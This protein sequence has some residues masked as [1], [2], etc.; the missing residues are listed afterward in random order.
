METQARGNGPGREFKP[1]KTTPVY[2][3]VRDIL[4]ER[5]EAGDWQDGKSL[6][7]EVDL[8][9]EYGVSQGTIRKALDM[10]KA[11]CLVDREQGRG[12]FVRK[13]RE[14]AEIPQS[15]KDLLSALG[16]VRPTEEGVLV[17]PS[18]DD[19]RV[20][21]A[22]ALELAAWLDRK[23]KAAAKAKAV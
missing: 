20:L 16:G 15:A 7:A 17:G 18:A 11:E 5:I 13:H 10:M 19:L 22:G 21:A 4:V 2:L 8:A 14:W 1:M 3:Q 9:R 12:T 6:P 23:A